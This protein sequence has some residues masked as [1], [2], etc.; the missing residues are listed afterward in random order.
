MEGRTCLVTGATHGIGFCTAEALARM[1]ARVVV[2]GRNPER[3]ATVERTLRE[4][5]GSSA[6]SGVVA[7][8]SSL[9]AVGRMAAELRAR[10]ERLDVLINNAGGLT[11]ER[12]TTR[13]GFEWHFG[14]NHLAPFLL[15]NLL[16]PSIHAGSQS[17]IVSVA[18]D[19]HRRAA[20]D[21]DDLN[22]ERGYSGR[23]AYARSKFANILFAAEL[24]RRLQGSGVTSNSLHPGVVATNLFDALKP[25]L[26]WILAVLKPLLL[27]PKAG[28][29]TSIYLAT[30]PEVEGVSGQYFTQCREHAPVPAAT[31]ADLGRRL[32]ERSAQLCGIS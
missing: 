27:S 19:A 20:I 3:V 4:R 15:T 17:R 12:Q 24:A 32:W 1:G 14:V 31:D 18:S 21:L 26:S 28:A 6:I 13:D 9:D 8:F 2:H 7:D 5:T 11:L 29:K 10:H 25:P 22:F 23:A 30:S 16:L